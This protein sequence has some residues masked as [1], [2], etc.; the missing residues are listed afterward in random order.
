MNDH[1]ENTAIPVSATIMLNTTITSEVSMTV[2]DSEEGF[3]LI[4]Y[5]FI[6]ILVGLILLIF[7]MVIIIKRRK[8]YVQELLP[9]GVLTIKPGGLLLPS[10]KSEEVTAILESVKTPTSITLD[11]VDKQQVIAPPKQVPALPSYDHSELPEQ[12]GVPENV[13]NKLETEIE[14]GEREG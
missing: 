5:S 3:D 6:I 1:A 11:A 8:R 13:Q 4:L 14:E 12:A 10:I 9:P 7:V 2:E